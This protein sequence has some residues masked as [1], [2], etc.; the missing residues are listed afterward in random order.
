MMQPNLHV[1]QVFNQALYEQLTVRQF[2]T[3]LTDLNKVI[4][5]N[6]LFVSDLLGYARPSVFIMET[7]TWL[8]VFSSVAIEVLMLYYPSEISSSIC[9]VFIDGINLSKVKHFDGVVYNKSLQVI[10]WLKE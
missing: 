4:S 8:K 5:E 2:L 7:P 6:V 9:F 10:Y 3:G 1:C